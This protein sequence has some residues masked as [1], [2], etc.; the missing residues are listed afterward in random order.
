M[1]YTIFYNKGFIKIETKILHEANVIIDE[2]IEDEFLYIPLM[3]TGAS[4]IRRLN[5]NNRYVREKSWGRYWY[6]QS[7]FFSKKELL[8][9]AEQNGNTFK[10]KNKPFEE[11]EFVKWVNSGIKK[12]LTVEEYS[13]YNDINISFDHANLEFTREHYCVPKTSLAFAKFIKNYQEY[14]L[15][16][17][18]DNKCYNV[19]AELD[20]EFK[21]NKIQKRPFRKK[22]KREKQLVK[23][24]FILCNS[25]G[26][27]FFRKTKYGFIYSYSHQS[28]LI[29]TFKKESDAQK[30]LNVNKQ[31][32]I[33]CGESFFIK[34]IEE[35]RYI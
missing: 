15:F 6:N 25:H 18:L 7:I 28:N 32:F 22:T 11:G 29:K 10:A 26:N 14:M 23:E 20:I 1:G 24:Y 35:E 9:L 8:N 33:D 16:L 2:K 19:Y 12:A 13:Q 17:M 21:Q 3:L 4:N 30:Y 31:M 27:V 34:K 5:I